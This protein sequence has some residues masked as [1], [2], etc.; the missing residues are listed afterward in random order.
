[1][2]DYGYTKLWR[3]KNKKKLA[4]QQARYRQKHKER[5][6]NYYKQWREQNLESYLAYQYSRKK[7]VK[8]ATP[9]W[10][11]LEEIRQ[12]YLNCPQG[13][14]VDHIVPINGKEVSGLHV[15]WNLQYLSAIENLKKGNRTP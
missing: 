13:H 7:R 15:P 8:Q 4:E 1:M 5:L 12:I 14:H 9:S 6:A 10:V 2:S 3:T 11:D